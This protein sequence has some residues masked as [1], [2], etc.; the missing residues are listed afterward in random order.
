MFVLFNQQLE[1]NEEVYAFPKGISSKV[2]VTPRPKFEHVYHDV[3]VKHVNNYVRRWGWL[4]GG[5][6]LQ[7]INS[8]RVI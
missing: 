4:I 1:G 7:F 3:A 6:V 2:D 8:F 5:L